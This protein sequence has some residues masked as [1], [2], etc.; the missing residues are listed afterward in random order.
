[1]GEAIGL[2]A[3]RDFTRATM[4]RHEIPAGALAVARG[5]APLLAEGFGTREVGTADLVTADTLFGVASVTKGLTALAIM[6]LAEAGK[7]A[8]DDPV[9]TY[10]AAYRTP[11]PEWARATTLH[12][13]LTHTAGLPPLPSRFFA[14]A[15]ATAG[16]P[17]AAARP[18][19]VADHAPLDNADDLLAYLADLDFVPLGAPG[20]QFNY[21]NEGFA[22]LGAIIERVSDRP[23]ADY[24]RESILD[25]LGM[26]RSTFDRAPLT[27]RADVA[28]LHVA[29]DVDG[30]RTI[31][32]APQPSYVPLWY[33]A[34]GLNSTANELLRYLEIYC[35][36]GLSGGARLLSAAGIARMI[37]P[38]TPG[39][40]PG[41]SYGYGL[42]VRADYH[43][44]K[45]VQ[46]GGGSKG[47]AS[48]VSV[49]PERDLTAVAL[50]NLAE[51]PADRLA[52]AP[53]NVLLGLPVDTPFV[54]YGGADLSPAQRDR[55]VGTYR[56]G[57]GQQV[58]VANTA[59]GLTV[60]LAGQEVVAR[61]VAD[62]AVV[63]PMPS[64]EL[65]ARFLLRGDDPAWAVALGSRIVPRA[66][67]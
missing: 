31:A 21:C 59:D 15:R 7:L 58:L 52:L 16:D 40:G 49:V 8:V 4:A 54:E 33:A 30:A 60:R 17:L 3:A 41:A 26:T 47:I 34:G 20:G 61:P 62:D 56:G 5:G 24:V 37:T 48:H 43:G 28:T 27:G 12:H 23:Y 42:G 1:M 53:I 46:H 55:F 65:Y 6:Q 11:R 51:V 25:P 13:F 66:E 63:L 36:G 18:A 2:A 19:W 22:L 50:T 45:V 29:R 39:G 67:A 10:L 9:G 64:G 57:E 32:P 35:T 44:V 14:L 38:H